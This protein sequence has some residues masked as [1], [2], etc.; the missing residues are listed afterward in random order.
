[1]EWQSLHWAEVVMCVGG[2][3]VAAVPL[4]QDVQVP[5]TA[6]WSTRTLVQLVETWQSSHVLVDAICVGGLPVALVPL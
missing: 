3:P 6:L 2:L 1:M 5:V 4:W